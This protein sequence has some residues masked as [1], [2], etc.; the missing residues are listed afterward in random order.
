MVQSKA[1]SNMFM[2]IAD[3]NLAIS[4][5]SILPI[6]TSHVWHVIKMPFK[7]IWCAWLRWVRGCFFERIFFCNYNGYRTFSPAY[8]IFKN[9]RTCTHKKTHRPSCQ[10]VGLFL[11]I[12]VVCER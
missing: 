12:G 9:A 3:C 7:T 8:P 6:I 4:L 10:G 1:V 2:L 11:K 5:V